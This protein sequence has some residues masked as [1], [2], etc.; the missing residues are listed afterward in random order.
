M[1]HQSWLAF[2]ASIGSSQEAPLY[3][4]WT[5]P[6]EDLQD[7]FASHLWWFYVLFAMSAG[8]T[9]VRPAV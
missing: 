1:T 3:Q 7:I 8:S 6:P 4:G 2:G 9:D 5:L